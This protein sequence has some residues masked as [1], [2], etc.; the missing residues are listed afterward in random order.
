MSTIFLGTPYETSQDEDISAHLSTIVASATGKVVAIVDKKI[1]LTNTTTAKVPVGIATISTNPIDKLPQRVIKKGSSV[2]VRFG[3]D[4]TKLLTEG[5]L[6]YVNLTD[7]NATDSNESGWVLGRLKS[8]TDNATNF[9]GT[10]YDLINDV[11]IAVSN[12]IRI[13]LE[14]YYYDAV[15]VRKQANSTENGGK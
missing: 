9:V 14:I 1:S 6:I 11:K 8:F 4:T 2:Y 7:S 10:C 3:G 12:C 13:D 5:Q 15:V